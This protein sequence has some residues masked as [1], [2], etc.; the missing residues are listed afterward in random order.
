MKY[1]ITKNRLLKNMLI[2]IFAA[3]AA[4]TVHAQQAVIRNLAGTVEVKFSGS[5]VWE[6][7][8]HG[9]IL[10]GKTTI[11]TGFRST[12]VISIGSSLLTV[13]PL[14]RLTLAELIKSEETERTDL[15][16]QSGRIR[17]EV[18]PPPGGRVEFTIR[19]SSATTSVRGTAFEVDTLGVA[20]SEGVVQFSGFFGPPVL[21][22]AGGISRVNELTGRV[23]LPR[24][25]AINELSPE[26]PVASETVRELQQ[27]VQFV[28]DFGQSGLDIF[29]Y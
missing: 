9:Q 10:D 24:T 5:E 8:H 3:A 27:P 29:I 1:V 21:V 2:F 15:T 26:L 18:T 7:A 12:A 11:S 22:D 14:T 16:L 4:G 20:V 6:N 28:P 17:A 23:A 13:R 19:S 25:E